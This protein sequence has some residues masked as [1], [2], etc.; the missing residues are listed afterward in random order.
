[1]TTYSFIAKAGSQFVEWN[2][3]TVWAGGVFPNSSDANVIFPTITAGGN[4]YV[5][6][7]TIGN[8]QSFLVNSVSLTNNTLLD[9]GTLSVTNDFAIMTGGEIDMMGTLSVGSLENDGVDIQGQGQVNVA[10]ALTNTTSIIGSGLTVTAAGLTNSGKLQAAS[11]NLT[12]NVNSGGFTNL[13]G[14]TLSGGTYAAGFQGNTTPNVLDLNVGAV[15]TVDAATIQLDGGGAI[16]SFDSGSAQYIPL[17]S[18]LATIAPSGTLSLADQAYNWGALTDQ[19]ALSLSG[20]TFSSP[21][22]TVAKGGTVIGVGTI[23]APV[24]NAGT[25]IAGLQQVPDFGPVPADL[26]KITGAVTGTGAIEVG[27]SIIAFDQDVVATLELNGPVSENVAFTDPSGTLILDD[28]PGFTGAIATGT[29]GGT[30]LLSGDSFS[31]VT[32]YSYSGNSTGGTLTVQ[33]SGGPIAINFLGDLDRSDFTLAAGPQPL[34]TSPPS[35]MITVTPGP[36]PAPTGLALSPGSDTGV[37][38]DDVTTVRTP[39]IT[40]S[41]GEA[42]ETVTLTDGGT[43]VGQG[44]VAA[45]GTWSIATSPLAFGTHGFIATQAAGGGPPSPASAPLLVTIVTGTPDYHQLGDVTGDGTSDLLFTNPNGSVALLGVTDGQVNSQA[46]IGQAG[47][48]WHPQGFGDFNGDGTSDL[49]WER[50]DGTLL[51]WT[52]QNGQVVG[53]PTIGQAGLEWHIVGIGDVTGDGTS[54]ILWQR[55]SD[56]LVMSWN[57]NNDQVASSTTLGSAGFSWHVAGVGDFTGTGTSDIL[58]QNTDGTVLD[59]IMT[60]GMVTGVATLGQAGPEWHVAG[61]GKFNGDGTDDILWQRTDG[62][63]L[64]WDIENNQVTGTPT[65]GQIGTE[66]QIT[67]VG[68]LTG[69]GGG[70]DIETERGSDGALAFLDVQHNQ[71]V[72][73]SING[74]VG[75]QWSL[76]G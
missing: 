57:I 47:A 4:I 7:V 51:D 71:V 31:S 69:A 61:V 22:L 73:T 67:D 6:F 11:G 64:V 32:G 56:G 33:L 19:G 23:A 41:G 18:S 63:L 17:Q 59:W 48:E 60:N 39:V 34:S 65:I 8:G 55:S 54:D 70:A 46:V 74:N 53:T 12:I 40:G 42:G 26:L 10:G 21:Q 16:A 49:L 5:S 20:A 3:P 37:L 28:Q 58:W 50:N 15:I 30:I 72:A 24:S 1:M 43:V 36:P 27:G 66:W 13:S 75:G 35:L 52:M 14:S 25:I 9:D 29:G 68:N 45:N 2:D 62:T 76:F 38:G 44:T